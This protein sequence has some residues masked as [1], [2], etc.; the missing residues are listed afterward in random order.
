MHWIHREDDKTSQNFNSY[1]NAWFF[2]SY[3]YDMYSMCSLH[4]VWFMF[5]CCFDRITEAL[6]SHPK[7]A[8][9][10]KNGFMSGRQCYWCDSSNTSSPNCYGSVW[11]VC[12]YIQC[13]IMCNRRNGIW[14]TNWCNFCVGYVVYIMVDYRVI[15]NRYYKLWIHDCCLLLTWRTNKPRRYCSSYGT[16][17]T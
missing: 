11:I 9:N 5:I 16:Y 15:M 1:N 17:T 3:F 4:V 6:L 10:N 14:S 12:W 2:V 13:T 7:R 8:A